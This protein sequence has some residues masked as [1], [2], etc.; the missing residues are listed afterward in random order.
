M[1]YKTLGKTGL[2]V[3]QICLG[4]MTW[5]SQNSEAEAHRQLD[6]AIEHGINF[7]DTAEAYPTTP[8]TAENLGRTEEYIGS[9][10]EKC[11]NRADLIVATKVAGGG[12]PHI[13]EGSPLSP[14]SI[15]EAVEG[16]LTRLRTDYI[17]LYQLHWPNRGHYH[18]RRSWT[19][20]PT[21]QSRDDTRA[22]ILELLQAL[23]K[24]VDAGK[25]RHIGLS[26]ETCWGTS[27]YLE[28]AAA[29]GL[30][31]VESIQ[32]EYSLMQRLFDLDFAELSHNEDVGLLAYS[33][34]AAGFLSGKYHNG[35]M[36]AGS[37][38]SI[39]ET[40]G[41]RYSTHSIPV[42]DAYLAV[43]RKH[44]LDPSQMALA[45]CLTRPFMTSVIIGATDLDQLRTN[46]G[47]VDLHLED[48]VMADVQE[49]YRQYPVPM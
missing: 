38:R 13:R 5:G 47:A 12:N 46:I 41:G 48:A 10:L 15:R 1:K 37:R 17:D 23:Q 31:R 18:F 26:N 29:N 27:Q 8:S 32:N 44:D 33:P 3:S 19:Y 43:A 34:L 4:S 45:F 20:D 42:A 24:L 21:G 25:I 40:L 36:P 35:A 14:T 28:I 22:H 49:V 2:K 39:N 9:W 16:S 11:A 7:I 30:P 6:Y